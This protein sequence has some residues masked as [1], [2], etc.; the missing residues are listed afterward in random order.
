[1]DQADS[2]VSDVSALRTLLLELISTT[3][4]PS[5]NLE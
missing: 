1:M 4:T 2:L 3:A 5:L